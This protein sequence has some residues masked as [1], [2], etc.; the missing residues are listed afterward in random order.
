VAYIITTSLI[1]PRVQSRLLNN[2]Y[3]M[4]KED[5]KKIYDLVKRVVPAVTRS[6]IASIFIEFTRLDRTKFDL[7]DAFVERA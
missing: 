1:N 6:N 3:D 5:P 2:G 4:D 7:L